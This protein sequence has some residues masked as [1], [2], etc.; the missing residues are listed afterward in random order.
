M[1]SYQLSSAI[2]SNPHL[3]S[4]VRCKVTQST[5][6]VESCLLQSQ[7]SISS[8]R[9]GTSKEVP[10]FGEPTAQH[11]QRPSK[12]VTDTLR[13]KISIL[14]YCM[15]QQF[16]LQQEFSWNGEPAGCTEVRYSKE[17]R[18]TSLP[19]HTAVIPASCEFPWQQ[20]PSYGQATSEQHS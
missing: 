19:Q 13:G 18:S 1:V 15:R 10:D 3:M 14:H 9:A 5:D 11:L 8:V 6:G 2:S 20:L 12:Y 16:I 7:V 4:T 17:L